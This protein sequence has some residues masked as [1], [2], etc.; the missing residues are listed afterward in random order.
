MVSRRNLG[1]DLLSAA[2]KAQKT[3][4]AVGKAS[5]DVMALRTNALY[6]ALGFCLGSGL[7]FSGLAAASALIYAPFLVPL[8][9]V[10]GI[11]G[12]TLVGRGSYDRDNE[13]SEELIEQAWKL[14]LREIKDLQFLLKAAPRSGNERAKLLEKITMLALAPP[15]DLYAHYGLVVPERP[16]SSH[17]G[18]PLGTKRHQVIAG[19]NV[20]MAKLADMRV[21]GEPEP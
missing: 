1:I 8:A 14:R 3:L 9:G 17:A 5:T 7:V 6:G 21:P 19:D 11:L 20:P 4:K 12:G 15:A 10:C 2:T 18:P 16:G 13:R